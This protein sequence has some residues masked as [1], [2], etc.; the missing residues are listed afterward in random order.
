MEPYEIAGRQII[1]LSILVLYLGSFITK[2][3]RFLQNNNIPVA[4]TGGLICSIVLAIL[5]GFEI[6][7]LTFDLSLRNLLL[8]LFF[9]TIGLNAKFKFL[10]KGGYALVLL[11]AVCVI[12]LVFQNIIG[13]SIAKI[14]GFEPF[15]GLFGGSISLAGGHGTSI[16]WGEIA[17]EKG[18]KGAAEFGIACAT[19]GLILGGLI[20]G[21]IAG[22]LIKKHSLQP[23]QDDLSDMQQGEDN[24]SAT[25][26]HRVTADDIINTI[27]A[28]ALCLGLGDAV[29]RYLFS[30]EIRLPGFLTALLAGIILTNLS[31][32][33]KMKLNHDGID[34]IG[35]VSLQLFLA[36]SLMSMDLLSLADSAL[37]LAVTMAFQISMITF[38]AIQVV[39]RLMGSD[40][41]AA[42]ITSGF[43]G[44]GLGATPVAI[45]NMDAVSQKHG[46]SLKALLIV[47]IV[48]AFFIDIINSFIIQ[49]FLKIPFFQ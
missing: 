36:M 30:Y 18:V 10:I 45:A 4:V 22:R 42:I 23:T 13:V 27:F 28:L 38:F 3:S 44:L 9:S 6:V 26:Y 11:V 20:G 1:L 8:L 31:D 35:G 15:Y 46:P 37:L 17:T 33:V 34:L 32:S 5:S 40:Y 16:A 25:G 29:N 21:P 12:F 43:I 24:H 7:T 41:D 39:F 2:R 19:F 48:G 47:P 49:A 14:M